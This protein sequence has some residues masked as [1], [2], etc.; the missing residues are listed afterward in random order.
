VASTMALLALAA[1]GSSI[2]SRLVIFLL[3]YPG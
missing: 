2:H 1:L 3:F